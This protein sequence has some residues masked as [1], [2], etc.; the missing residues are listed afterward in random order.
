MASATAPLAAAQDPLASID[1]CLKQLDPEVDIG[2]QRIAAR[3]PEL[4]RRLDESG[5]SAWLPR[6]W[7][8]PGN[9]LSGGSLQELRVLVPRELAARTTARVPRVERLHAALA[10]L[11]QTGHERSRWWARFKAWLRAIFERRAPASNESWL[12]RMISRIGLSQAMIELVS[13]AALALVVVLAGFIVV[14]ELRTAGV[15]GARRRGMAGEDPVRAVTRRAGLSWHDVEQASFADK[16]RLLLE[17]VIARLTDQ[18]CLPP[19]GGLTVRE[20]TRAARLTDADDRDRLVELALAAERVRFSH[21]EV[22]PASLEA[23]IRSGRELLERLSA[24]A[25]TVTA[26]GGRWP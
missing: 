16:P 3:C 14:N 10:E 17:L 25:S 19:A 2:Y 24:R 1:A 11:G 22:S 18:S 20:L 6:G 12:D 26:T 7:K 21:E 4:V 13:Y 23:A 8:E 9:D 5:W 15:L